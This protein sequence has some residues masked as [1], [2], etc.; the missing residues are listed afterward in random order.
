MESEKYYVVVYKYV[1]PN[2]GQNM[3]AD[4][5]VITTSVPRKNLSG[6][7]CE[8]GWCGA[9]NDC[10]ATALGAFGTLEEAKKYVEDEFETHGVDDELDDDELVV[11][12]IGSYPDADDDVA[13][14]WVES[15]LR[16]E[17]ELPGTDEEILTLAR[18]YEDCAN[19]QGFSLGDE[20][21]VVGFIEDYVERHAS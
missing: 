21:R 12:G 5:V 14:G 4:R 18:F 7:P 1:G 2:L 9:T 13:G 6:E 17:S 11:L 20:D 8:W 19:E 3:D 16:C 10:S 15:S